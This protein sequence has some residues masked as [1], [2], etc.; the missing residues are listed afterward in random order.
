M[1]GAAPQPMG[2]TLSQFWG[3][4]GMGTHIKSAWREQHMPVKPTG[5]DRHGNQTKA[6][7]Q[8]KR[9]GVK[10]SDFQL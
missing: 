9:A 1:H 4:R 7:G 3:M 8:P 2:G 5:T 6:R 10:K